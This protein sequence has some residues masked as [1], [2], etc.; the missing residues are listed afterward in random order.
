MADHVSPLSLRK[1]AIKSAVLQLKD[2]PPL[3]ERSFI[4][5]QDAENFSDKAEFRVMQW[6]VLAD[7]KMTPELK[8]ENIKSVN[9][10]CYI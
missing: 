7:G 1:E 6:N 10:K 8:I 9:K 3:L 4:P 2:F 5:T